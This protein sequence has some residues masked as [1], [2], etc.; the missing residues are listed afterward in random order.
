M[1]LVLVTIEKGSGPV[2]L[3]IMSWIII[4]NH[5]FHDEDD[6]LGILTE[7]ALK[8]NYEEHRCVNSR[9]S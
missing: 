5:A 8:D 1:I 4:V 6:D 9:S 3:T 7:R 2:L